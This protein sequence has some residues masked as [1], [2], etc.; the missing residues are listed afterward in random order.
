MNEQQVLDAPFGA[1]GVGALR[2]RSCALGGVAAVL[3]AAG[4]AH[5]GL[6]SGPGY[7]VQAGDFQLT[8][9]AFASVR[10]GEDFDSSEFVDVSDPTM[11]HTNDLF[12]SRILVGAG[13][14][15]FSN[16]FYSPFL[17]SPTDSDVGV[18]GAGAFV[19]VEG[20]TVDDPDFLADTSARANFFLDLNFT[21]SATTLGDGLVPAFITSNLETFTRGDFGSTNA[22]AF[23]DG[24]DGFLFDLFSDADQSFAQNVML[25]PGQYTLSLSADVD[26]NEIQ[27]GDT[28]TLEALARVFIFFGSDAAVD[29]DE[30]LEE[31]PFVLPP[32]PPI[33]ETEE[34]VPSPGAAVV[35]ALAGLG[36]LRRRRQG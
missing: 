17:S 28:A 25:T 2:V 20:A 26:F 16:A 34:F 13:S 27:S 8:Q 33:E 15:A 7:S 35:L 21:V 31:D 14:R 1:G 23:L 18:I 3:I 5:A 36:G 32:L 6:I 30:V 12:A 4:S 29:P 10:R 24:P 22:S 9:E 19:R 11:A